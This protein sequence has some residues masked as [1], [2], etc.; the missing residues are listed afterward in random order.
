MSSWFPSISWSNERVVPPLV[1]VHS[2][3]VFFFLLLGFFHSC[4][5]FSMKEEIGVI[6]CHLFIVL[7][8]W[9]VIVLK[10]V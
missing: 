1:C 5:L 4:E 8:L 6:L 3:F 9:E 10:G 7:C 2:Q